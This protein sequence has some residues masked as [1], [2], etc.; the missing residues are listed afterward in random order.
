MY[1]YGT[2]NGGTQQT[3]KTT[4][5]GTDTDPLTGHKV[6]QSSFTYDLSG[7]LATATVSTYTNG[8]LASQS[9][10]TYGYDP[11]ELRVSQQVTVGT[12]TTTTTYLMD[13][14]NPTGYAQTLEERVGGVLDRTYT[15]GLDV[16]AQTAPAV[17]V[18]L[19]AGIAAGD[20]LTLLYDGHG[21]T[22]ALVKGTSVKQRYAYDAYGN[23]LAGTGLSDAAGALTDLL[24]SG[25]PTDRQT[26]MQGLDHRD[27]DPS[28]GRFPTQDPIL[29]NTD[30]PISLHRYLYASANP[31]NRIDPSGQ[32]TTGEI[33]FVLGLVALQGACALGLIGTTAMLGSTIGKMIARPFFPSGIRISNGSVPAVD[34]EFARLAND[35]YGA[36]PNAFPHWRPVQPNTISGLDSAVFRSGSFHAELYKSTGTQGYA[37]VFEGT[38]SIGDWYSN[39]GQ[40]AL[41]PLLST[42]FDAASKLAMAV[43]K[44]LGP[45]TLLTMVGHSLGGGLADA[46]ALATNCPAVTFNA[47]GL[48]VFTELKY[49]AGSYTSSLANYRV[50]GEAVSMANDYVGLVS[51]VSGGNFILDPAAADQHADPISL[52]KMEAVLRALG[53]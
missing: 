4:W 3:D 43:R 38:T 11:D 42:Q 10:S 52:H 46:A 41:G 25:E 6:A 5:Q 7:R 49:G 18:V 8:T 35:V 36:T 15:L 12:T 40:G 16:L 27:Y 22:R 48:N 9:V 31:V 13:G 32:M 30:D 23:M 44:A 45:H 17:S 47:A 29:G 53:L 34:R 24:Y 50:N 1:A 39:F 26:G 20:V 2:D 19:P 51:G 14:N 37:L 28:T 33:G 21:S